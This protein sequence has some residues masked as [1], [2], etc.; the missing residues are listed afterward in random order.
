MIPITASKKKWFSD[1]VASLLL[2][3]FL[4]T[5]INKLIDIQSF[6]TT[7]SQS[8]YLKDSASLLSW[9]IPISEV[10]ICF[11]LFIPHYRKV[12]LLFGFILMGVFSL[13]VG[14]M[15]FFSKGLPCSCGGVIE[16][17]SWSQHL[18]F[19]IGFFILS[20]VA[21]ILKQSVKKEVIAINRLSRTP[22]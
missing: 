21:W 18:I 14:S 4:Y 6:E 11:L 2:F 16:T 12:G 1:I 15:I 10:V 17:M 22:V 9:G 5:A 3:L 8:P 19:N 13:Y 7:L 20:L